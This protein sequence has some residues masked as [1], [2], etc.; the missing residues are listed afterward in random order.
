MSATGKKLVGLVWCA[1]VIAPA[2]ALEL[3]SEQQSVLVGAE[4]DPAALDRA[5]RHANSGEVVTGRV[6][7]WKEGGWTAGPEDEVTTCSYGWCGFWPI[8]DCSLEHQDRSVGYTYGAC[9]SSAWG[10]R[11]AGYLWNGG[12]NARY[13]LH[14]SGTTTFGYHPYWCVKVG[15][16][17]R[18]YQGWSYQDSCSGRY[19]FEVT[20]DGTTV[21]ALVEVGLAGEGGDTVAYS[22]DIPEGGSDVSFEIFGGSGEVELWV[23]RDDM[24]EEQDYDC[25]A[26]RGEGVSTCSGEEGTHG[27]VVFGRGEFEDVSVRASYRV[28]TGGPECGNGIVEE[29]EECDGGPCCTDDCRFANPD[30]VCREAVGACDLAE[31]C[32]GDSA[33]CPDDEYVEEGVTCREAEGVC[34]LA[35][36]CTG[37]APLCPPNEHAPDGTECPDGSCFGGICEPEEAVDPSSCFA[38]LSCGGQAPGGCWCDSACRFYGDCCDDGPC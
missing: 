32:T 12:V 22:V 10:E 1:A 23:K 19:D 27:L 3:D 28:G 21:F 20:G 25:R 24:P 31:Y 2:C 30:Q 4:L 17:V 18:T 6:V 11:F 14:A 7:S 38:S 26:V 5:T 36:T 29:G 37:D 9:N 15:D 8:S 16:E 35:G 13:D 33:D 34:E